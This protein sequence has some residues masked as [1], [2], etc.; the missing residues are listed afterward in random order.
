MHTH[1]LSDKTIALAV[2]MQLGANSQ[3]LSLF[4]GLQTT[5]LTFLITHRTYNSFW[6]LWYHVSLHEVKYNGTERLSR[7]MSLQD[8][9]IH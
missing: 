7:V 1:R 3:K 9:P 5:R 8:M 2:G 6:F 4:V